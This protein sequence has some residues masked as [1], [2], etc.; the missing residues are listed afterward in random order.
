M[1]KQEDESRDHLFGCCSYV[2]D[3][4]QHIK[5]FAPGFFCSS[6]LDDALTVM[7]RMCKRKKSKGS[8]YV[9]LWVEMLYQTWLQHNLCVF[10]DPGFLALHVAHKIVFLV[11]ARLDYNC[12]SWLIA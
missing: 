2:R 1:C 4:S 5:T 11:V 6:S 8:M 3:L 10:G 9:M 12:K 7:S